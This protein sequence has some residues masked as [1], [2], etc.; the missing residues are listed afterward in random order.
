MWVLRALSTPEL[1]K[2][3]AWCQDQ[4]D[5]M[6]ET[7]QDPVGTDVWEWYEEALDESEWRDRVIE[8]EQRILY[9]LED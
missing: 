1:M 6:D 5:M 3:V 9:G 2:H 4:I 8:E 7:G